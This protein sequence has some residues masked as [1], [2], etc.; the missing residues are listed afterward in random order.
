MNN[1]FIEKYKNC[2][3]INFHDFK[4]DDERN[5]RILNKL[6][7][8]IVDFNKLN[9][10]ITVT[11]GIA[12]FLKYN[13]IYRSFKDIDLLIPNDSKTK[14]KYLNYFNN[15]FLIRPNQNKFDSIQEYLQFFIKYNNYHKSNK[16]SEF[17]YLILS[18]FSIDLKLQIDLIP[19]SSIDI[20][21]NKE[22]TSYDTFNC[23]KYG[24]R[25]PLKYIDHR[26]SPNQTL[27][28]RDID[29]IDIKFYEKYLKNT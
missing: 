7:E 23:I 24:Y 11:G 29:K 27:P 10:T 12:L 13:K 25:L 14:F 21:V 1:Y 5:K 3:K 2:E 28:T 16:Y 8:I 22:Y 19:Y 15:K 6:S 20:K 4:I 26:Y 9:E 17:D 18:L